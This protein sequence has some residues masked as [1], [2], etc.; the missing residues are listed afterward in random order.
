M[1]NMGIALAWNS[2]NDRR[3]RYSD[4]IGTAAIAVNHVF[5]SIFIPHNITQL[6]AK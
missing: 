2:H 6:L 3:I 1:K 5:I 4:N